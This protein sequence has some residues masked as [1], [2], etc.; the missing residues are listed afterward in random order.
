LLPFFKGNLTYRIFLKISVF[1]NNP[2]VGHPECLPGQTPGAE[3]RL[4]IRWEG[5]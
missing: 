2:G 3:G 5:D 4:P 1:K